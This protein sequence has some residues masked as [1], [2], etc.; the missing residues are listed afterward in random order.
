MQGIVKFGIIIIS[1]SLLWLWIRFKVIPAIN[2]E[3]K[4]LNLDKGY[5]RK[6]DYWK[7]LAKGKV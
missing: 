4:R 6:E 7:A 5:K 3:T 2:E 1:V